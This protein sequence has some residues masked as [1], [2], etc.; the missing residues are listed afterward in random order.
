MVCHGLL[1][2]KHV[3]FLLFGVICFVLCVFVFL[4]CFLY[5]FILADLFT[6]ELTIARVWGKLYVSCM[7]VL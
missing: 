2:L 5:G 3:L 4:F 6:V 7:S 1:A